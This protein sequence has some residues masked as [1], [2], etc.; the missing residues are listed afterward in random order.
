MRRH[1]T[2]PKYLSREQALECLQIAEKFSKEL[3]LMFKVMITTGIRVSDYINLK[4]ENFKYD[5]TLGYILTFKARKN[6]Q[7]ITAPITEDVYKAARSLKTLFPGTRWTAWNHVKQVGLTLGL[8]LTPHML[9]HTF[10]V[11]S[12]QAGIS[13]EMIASITGDDFQTLKDW[14]H[15]VDPAEVKAVRTRLENYLFK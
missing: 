5:P 6:K 7:E 1:K 9:R 3:Y 4:Q 2:I 11:L 12:R 13:W 15:H 14:Y 8:K 10:V